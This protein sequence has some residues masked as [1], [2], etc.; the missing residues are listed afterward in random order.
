MSHVSDL[1]VTDNFQKVKTLK[2]SRV[3]EYFGVNV[4]NDNAMKLYL[5]SEDIERLKTLALG[6]EKIDMPL[7]A[8]VAT[9]VREWALKKGATHFCHWFQPQTGTTAEKHDAFVWLDKDKNLI[10]R[11]T[12]ENLLQGE[13]DASSFPSGGVRS[14][15]EARGYTAWDFSSPMFVME[16]GYTKTLY[17]PSVFVSYNGVALDSKIPLLRSNL[18]LEKHALETL[19]Y[20]SDKNFHQISTTVGAEQEFFILDRKH[21][22]KRLDL[23]LTGRT[24]FGRMAPKGH[25]LEDHY[26]GSIPERILSFFNDL[27]YELYKLGIPIKTRHNEVAPS[28]FEIAPLYEDSNIA[29][30]HN[31]IVMKLL[32]KVGVKHGFSILLHEKPFQGING[33]GKHINWS[34]CADKHYNIFEPGK[35]LDENLIFLTFLTAVLKGINDHESMLRASI[36]SL[37]NDLRLGANEAPPAII[38]IFLGDY[39]EK[40]LT[41]LEN[42]DL[43]SREQGDEILGVGMEQ[44]NFIQKDNTDR[45]RTSP[46]AFTG[47]KFEFRAVGASSTIS[48]P[49]MVLNSVVSY[50]L[51]EINKI[52]REVKLTSSG[53]ISK[54]SL[55]EILREIVIAN[56]RIRFDGDGY[57]KSWEDEASKRGLSNLRST[58]DALEVL[59]N[60]SKNKFFRDL[61]VLSKTELASRYIIQK[62]IFMRKSLIEAKCALDMTQSLIM[63]A[64]VNALNTILQNLKLQ[65]D[66]SLPKSSEESAR[67]LSVLI[68][69]LEKQ[70]CKL[71]SSL[72][73]FEDDEDVTHHDN[74]SKTLI[75]IREDVIKEMAKLRDI[76][77]SLEEIVP[78]WP[79]PKYSDIL[80]EDFN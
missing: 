76:V 77:D 64:S 41:R 13:P 8:R 36:A 55:L 11:F 42:G 12:S 60:E 23:K 57:S 67:K 29:S 19:S 53:K 54:E 51:M 10:E 34:I 38:S 4:F 30:D 26:F 20:I 78:N 27:E 40:V 61:N 69:A 25:E 2:D 49:T 70:A 45:N 39:I 35:N 14:T 18:E 65:K 21:V 48:Y 80:F 1:K 72:A 79:Y 58:P 74:L 68:D 9:A 33:S 63:P 37:S 6:Q 28:Q 24:I 50:G 16:T 31:Y 75:S 17:I 62:E 56:K 47:N 3:K 71:K 22:S 59:S 44:L 15:F 5:S 46:F 32:K 7:V 73:K 43:K 66:L 52:I